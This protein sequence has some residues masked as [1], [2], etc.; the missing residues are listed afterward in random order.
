[1]P[2]L[3]PSRLARKALPYRLKAAESYFA[4]CKRDEEGHCKPSGEGEAAPKEERQVIGRGSTGEVVRTGSTVRKQATNSEGKIY[5]KLAGVPGI[6]AGKQEGGEIVTPYFKHVVSVDTIP[7]KQR[8]SYAPVIRKNLERLV[9]GLTALSQ[10]GADYND[11]LQVG[12]DEQ[13][14]ASIF[15]FSAASPSDSAVVDNLQHLG[16][17]LK[18]FGLEGDAAG[19]ARVSTLWNYVADESVRAF[20]SDSDEGKDAEKIA[21]RLDGQEPKYAYYS[22]NAREIPGV[23]QSE[24]RDRIKAI[25]A[26]EPLSDEFMRQW[27]I[28]PA[29][30]RTKPE[31][32]SKSLEPYLVK[33]AG[34]HKYGCLMALFSPED[35][36]A[37]LDW[38][39]AHIPD[40]ALAIGGRE[41]EPHITVKYGF[42]RDEPELIGSIA[43]AGGPITLRLGKISTFPEGSDGVPLK[44]DVDSPQLHTLNADVAAAS[45]CVDKFPDYMPHLTLA[46]IKPE[47]VPLL[48]DLQFPWSGKT[49]TL[50]SCEYSSA[51]GTRTVVPLG[52]LPAYGQKAGFTGKKEDKLGREHCYTDGKQTQCSPDDQPKPDQTAKQE[53]PTGPDA[54]LTDDP[55]DQQAQEQ[56]E[57]RQRELSELTP[58]ERQ[59]FDQEWTA[60]LDA[61]MAES[62]VSAHEFTPEEVA[63]EQNWHGQYMQWRFGTP[64]ILPP[65]EAG[66]AVRFATGLTNGAVGTPEHVNQL[67]GQVQAEPGLVVE[68]VDLL[69]RFFELL[70]ELLDPT[71]KV[72]AGTFGEQAGAVVQAASK[73]TQLGGKPKVTQLASSRIPKQIQL[74]PSTVKERAKL[75]PNEGRYV[76]TTAPTAEQRAQVQAPTG[77]TA[78]GDAREIANRRNKLKKQSQGK[79]RAFDALSPEE[80]AER[81]AKAKARRA[82]KQGRQEKES[83]DFWRKRNAGKKSLPHKLKDMSWLDSSRGGALV[84]P[85]ARLPP[86]RLRKNLTY[87]VKAEGSYFGTCERDERGH[88]LPSGETGTDKPEETKPAPTEDEPQGKNAKVQKRVEKIL[89]DS[90]QFTFSDVRAADPVDRWDYDGIEDRMTREEKEEMQGYLDEM[91]EN[92]I[93][94][95]SGDYETD[96]DRTE[97]TKD[98]GFNQGDID[99]KVGELI[100]GLEDAEAWQEAMG[101]YKPNRS[102]VG[103]DYLDGL[104]EALKEAAEIPDDLQEQL[105]EYRSQMV[106]E[107]DKAVESQEEYRRSNYKEKLENDYDEREDKQQ[108]LSDFYRENRDRYTGGDCDERVWCKDADGDDRMAFSTNSGDAYTMLGVKTNRKFEGEPVTDIQF[109]DAKGSFEVTGGGNAFEVFSTVVPATVSYLKEKNPN[110]ATFSAKGE[111]RQRL[112]DRLAKSVAGVM[113]E[114]FVAMENVGDVRYY[115]VGKKALRDKIMDAMKKKSLEIPLLKNPQELT[116]EVNPDWWEPSAWE[117]HRPVTSGRLQPSRL[118]RRPLGKSL[119]GYRVKGSYFETCERDDDGHCKPSGQAEEPKKQK[120]STQKPAAKKPETKPAAKQADKPKVPE[121]E[122]SEKAKRAKAAHKMVDKAIQR[123]AEEF[124]EPRFAKVVK[125]ISHPDSEPMDVTTGSGDLVEM[126]TLVDNSNNKITMDSYSQVRKIVKEKEGGVNFHTVVSDDSLIYKADGKHD[127]SQPRTYYYRRGVAGS[128]RIGSMHKCK[129]EAELK[130]LMAMDEK[131]LPEGAQRTDGKLRVGKWKFFQDA[132]GKGYKNQKTGQIVR[133]KK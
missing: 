6:A 15:D 114:Y 57:Q 48:A 10:L 9:N 117:E 73:K 32:G 56:G 30:H 43:A 95:L 109:S 72:L 71:A 28:Y 128:A 7:E 84:P 69:K 89:K 20:D 118:R 107:T 21:S 46:Y 24:P 122:L 127:E 112:Y 65:E 13:K 38:T 92:T 76:E 39:A 116:P 5:E 124:N 1:M 19:M 23:A 113:D 74:S 123:Y 62:D 35:S 29:V 91:R 105:D 99:D 129:D 12:F 45:E 93:N 83:A 133:A 125:G 78:K 108:Y 103:E 85:P 51:D 25:F 60:A 33:G 49:L 26:T 119:P 41:T 44:V 61:A 110:V 115:V 67:A 8:K 120:P 75:A 88:C 82:K 53:E 2:T 63:A 27:E 59:Q 42:T 104:V 80:R 14:Q 126:K 87:A 54:K 131:A 4:S 96:V 98:Q 31:T 132:E 3:P 130:Q 77:P 111:S 17:Y 47:F 121:Q 22:Y 68:I 34:P 90:E 97:V 102:V 18:Q 100:E 106:E 101:D 40:S 36:R 55:S 16:G 79:Q 11:P 66:K 50:T 37:I 70:P 81:V 52:I 58:E 94:E 64:G 86:S